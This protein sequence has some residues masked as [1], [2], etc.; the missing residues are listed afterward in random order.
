MNPQPRAITNTHH[1]ATRPWPDDLYIQ[2][3]HGWASSKGYHDE[4]FFEAMGGTPGT[5]L[6]GTGP[7]MADAETKVWQVWQH[8]AACP[9]APAHGPFEPRGYTNGAGY[10]TGCGSWFSKVLPPQP[11]PEPQQLVTEDR[12]LAAVNYLEGKYG[13]P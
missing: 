5:F 12:L 8:M 11:E 3:G 1:T 7:T 13:N 4:Y 10:C 2:G 6:R 9:A